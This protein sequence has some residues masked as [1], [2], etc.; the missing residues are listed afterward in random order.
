MYTHRRKYVLPPSPPTLLTCFFSDVTFFSDQTEEHTEDLVATSSRIR[1][2]IENIFD[3]M[4]DLYP[5]SISRI[6]ILR[7]V[8]DPLV[9]RRFFQHL[10][11]GSL[12]L[13]NGRSMRSILKL[14]SNDKELVWWVLQVLGTPPQLGIEFMRSRSLSKRMKAVERM[15]EAT[16]KSLDER[17]AREQNALKAPVGVLKEEEEE[18]ID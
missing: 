2:A 9:V 15:L 3:T 11:D 8:G 12:D 17:V 13:N 18:I 1:Q 5:Q 6:T 16:I 4:V 10:E 7:M 14:K